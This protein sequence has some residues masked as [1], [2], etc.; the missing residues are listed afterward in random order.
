[1]P[2]SGPRLLDAV[3][4]CLLGTAA[5]D[6]LGLPAEGL[7]RR[8]QAR[9]LGAYDG[10]RLVLGRGMTSDD[11]EHACMTA[12]ALVASAGDVDV[13]RRCLARDVR[14]WFLTLPAGVG[15]ATLR[16]CLKLVVGVSPERSGVRSAG[17]G[18]CMRSPIL[19][20]CH[21]DEPAR[22]AALVRASTHL[23][24]RDP[25]AEGGALAVALAAWIAARGDA[26]MRDGFADLLAGRLAVS[27][28]VHETQE[29]T[30]R[31]DDA[32]A[33]ARA[34][35]STV[36]F[37][38]R[39]AGPTG[40][41]GYVL[42]TVPVALHAWLRHPDRYRDAVLGVIRAGGDSDTTAAITGGI[43]GA[44]VGVQGIPPAWLD[45]L[46]EWPRTV[47]WMTALARELAA[48]V[49]DG[50]PRRPPSLSTPAVL[51]RNV[52]FLAI[53]LAHGFRRALPPY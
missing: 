6:A 17:N 49:A 26:S 30:A 5:G 39:I 40:V 16:A 46:C 41:S 38:E 43:V 48:V 36:T 1:M 52:A 14:V 2:L 37:A 3:S 27:G 18:P 51:V 44:G 8:R 4:G 13:F 23:T 24:H 32:A 31:I 47:G 20:V 28:L 35:E 53:V 50:T 33:S 22:L 45:G 15:F 11:T 10:H 25:R 21:G 34:G 19:G 42:H 7:S 12:Q 29:L 9:M